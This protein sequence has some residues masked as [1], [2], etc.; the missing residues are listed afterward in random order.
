MANQPGFTGKHAVA[1]MFLVALGMGGYAWWH[2]YRSH[3]LSRAWWGTAT[4]VLIETAPAVDLIR[5]DSPDTSAVGEENPTVSTAE[6]MSLIGTPGLVHARH[7]LVLDTSYDWSAQPAPSGE[8]DFA[9]RFRS[10]ADQA[11]IRFDLEQE[12]IEWVEEDRRL[13][14]VPAIAAAFR[15]KEQD[16]SR[17]ARPVP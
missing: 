14:M 7:A 1:V 13:R 5:Y 2:N 10:G 8:W 16:W 15:K 3:P 17:L 12:R 4:I 6:P 9:L 11:T